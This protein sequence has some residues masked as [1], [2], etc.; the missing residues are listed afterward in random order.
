MLG[1]YT[2]KKKGIEGM[3]QKFKGRSNSKLREK[4]MIRVYKYKP[5]YDEPKK[6]R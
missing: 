5:N 4:S 3:Y 2:G 6:R 1:S